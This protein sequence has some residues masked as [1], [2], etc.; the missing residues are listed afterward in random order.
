MVMRGPAWLVGLAL[1]LAGC[2]EI[3]GIAPHQLAGDGDVDGGASEPDSSNGVD[4]GSDGAS[5]AGSG[6]DAN[7][8]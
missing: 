6:S 8:G 7:E 4:S 2:D 1:A 3:V 5:D